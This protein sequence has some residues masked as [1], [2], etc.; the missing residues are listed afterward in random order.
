MR[1]NG[2][3][4]CGSD[5][6]SNR[7]TYAFNYNNTLTPPDY[8]INGSNPYCQEDYWGYYNGTKSAYYF[9]KE[10]ANQ[11]ANNFA[12]SPIA[13]YAQGFYANNTTD[14]NPSETYTKACMLQEIVYPTG[15]KTAF[16]YEINHVPNFYSIIKGHQGDIVGG[17]RLKKRTNYSSDGAITDVKE[18]EYEGYPIIQLSYDMFIAPIRS[19]IPFTYTM[20]YL[21]SPTPDGSVNDFAIY[22]TELCKSSPSLSITGWYDNPVFYNKVTEYAGEKANNNNIGRTVYT[23]SENQTQSYPVNDATYDV[24]AG[25]SPLFF[26]VYDDWDKG[27]I[28]E[29][30][31]ATIVF[32]KTGDTVKMIQNKYYLYDIPYLHT[33][34]HVEQTRDFHGS[35]L[36]LV[37]NSF[38]QA[39]FQQYYLD[40]IVS[41]NNYAIQQVS[42][43][44]SA[45]ETDYVNGK[46][47][48]VDTKTY[49]YA[50]KNSMP[51]SFQPSTI[52]HT[53]SNGVSYTETNK[54]PFD[55]T[56]APYTDMVA[57]N[58][59]DPVVNKTE[60]SS[61]GASQTI[62]NNYRKDGSQ[63]VIDNVQTGKNGVLESRLSYPNYDKYGNLLYAVK[64]NAT[65]IVYLWGYNGLYPVAKITGCDYNTVKA[66]VDTS[67]LNMGTEAVIEDRLNSLRNYFN[68]IPS[69]QIS[70]Y[71]Y[72]PL[73]GMTSAT[74]PNGAV[75]KYQ[76]D[77][78]GR[79]ALTK[80]TDNNITARYG[81]AY[82]GEQNNNAL[83]TS[84]DLNNAHTINGGV[85]LSLEDH[86]DP[87]NIQGKT[88]TFTIQQYP[89]QVTIDMNFEQV[90]GYINI[91]IPVCFIVTI[92]D[93][94]KGYN[95]Y[96]IEASDS[97]YGS[98]STGAYIYKRTDVI[99]LQPGT[100]TVTLAHRCR[101][102]TFTLIG[103]MGTCNVSFTQTL[104]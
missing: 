77:S 18:Y 33:G 19:I 38:F 56:F 24:A 91:T 10:I 48:V 22:E 87:D 31:N 75:T 94:S 29:L 85:S 40:G 37:N 17:L 6:T 59:I 54:Y 12:N 55:Y 95:V 73:I 2:I 20:A 99:T 83:Q 32:N 63:F 28:K 30:P 5:T 39:S 103:H 68:K 90:K 74:A 13:A 34:V 88:G 51:I 53:N 89:T 45:T 9:P 15:G 4:L 79:L 1:L 102:P 82:R 43:P 66:L 65:K 21:F 80:N 3:S 81:Y 67:A 96:N 86:L 25:Y 98:E 14:R 71:T 50:V 84:I 52:T 7:E 93:N 11:V 76:Y 35:V 36:T 42:L 8:D 70:T 44:Q 16:E 60:T 27:Y 26:S 97:K 64:D 100:Y 46:P 23:Y 101:Y 61:N 57:A 92:K 72:A 62:Q 78:L 49:D 47:A 69:V 104:P 58:I 41:V